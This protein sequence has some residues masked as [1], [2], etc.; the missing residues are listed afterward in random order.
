MS[1]RPSCTPFRQAP[2]CWVAAF[3]VRSPSDSESKSARSSGDGT[4]SRV[5]YA[6]TMGSHTN[7]LIFHGAVGIPR[8]GLE[9][10]EFA[11]AQDK[12]SGAT[13]PPPHPRPIFTSKPVR[14]WS[15][16]SALGS[17]SNHRR[18]ESTADPRPPRNSDRRTRDGLRTPSRERLSRHR[19]SESACRVGEAA[20]R[21]VRIVQR[22]PR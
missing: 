17:V 5:R 18:A 10:T 22:S 16:S 8:S 9:P 4:V 6:S 7:S 11:S 15:R 19:S 14:E 1:Y 12:A 13:I 2:S 3:R 20:R 21:S